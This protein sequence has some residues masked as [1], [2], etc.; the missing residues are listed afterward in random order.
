MSSILRVIRVQIQTEVISELKGEKKSVF[1]KS[2]MG[3]YMPD[4]YRDL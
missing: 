3:V 2:N 1:V 4:L